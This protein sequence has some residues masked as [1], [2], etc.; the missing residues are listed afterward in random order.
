MFIGKF[1]FISKYLEK[2]LENKTKIDGF[3]I[4]P[5]KISKLNIKFPVINIL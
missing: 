2:K 1:E 4:F 5:Y 3:L